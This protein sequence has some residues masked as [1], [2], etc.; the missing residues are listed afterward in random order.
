MKEDGIINT[1]F[2]YITQLSDMG[3]FTKIILLFF[4]ELN[5]FQ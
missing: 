1:V 4:L 5:F 2:H 3:I